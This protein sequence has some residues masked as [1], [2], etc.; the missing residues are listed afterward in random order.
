[1][2]KTFKGLFS[3]GLVLS[4]LAGCGNTTVQPQ[5]SSKV[6]KAAKEFNLGHLNGFVSSSYFGTDINNPS[7]LFIK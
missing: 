1:M 6:Q 5:E 7:V 3:A 2:K 4:L